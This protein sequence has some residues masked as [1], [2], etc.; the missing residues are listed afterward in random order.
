MNVE[1]KDNKDL[2]VI[3]RNQFK[4]DKAIKPKAGSFKNIISKKNTQI[5]QYHK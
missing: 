2:K 4:I 1:E 5:Y 3:S